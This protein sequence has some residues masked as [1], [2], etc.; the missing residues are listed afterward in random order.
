[1]YPHDFT[2]THFFNNE[3][4]AKRLGL[5]HQLVPNATRVGVFVNPR[6]AVVAESTLQSLR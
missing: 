1:M 2:K 3:V 4:V 6:D 5:M